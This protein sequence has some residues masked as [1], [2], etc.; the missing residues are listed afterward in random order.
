MSQNEFD[1]DIPAR[2]IALVEKGRSCEKHGPKTPKEDA[3]FEQ[4]RAMQRKWRQLLGE[5][6]YDIPEDLWRFINWS[7]PETWY[8]PNRGYT[9]VNSHKFVLQ[10]PGFLPINVIY[11]TWASTEWAFNKFEIDVPGGYTSSA[12]Y[13]DL[14]FFLALA[15]RGQKPRRNKVKIEEI[16]TPK[17]CELTFGASLKGL[18]KTAAEEMEDAYAEWYH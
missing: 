9:N 10:L 18:R 6:K 16:K 13:H 3:L 11:K 12:K 5:A 14:P 4:H 15:H 7:M 1:A 17:G 2:I 8:K